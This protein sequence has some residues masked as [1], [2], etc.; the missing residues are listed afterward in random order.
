MRVEE[1]QE[2]FNIDIAWDDV[3]SAI[4]TECPEY[5]IE[6]AAALVDA[7]NLCR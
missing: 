5:Q 1:K 2:S 6:A 7:S 3:R 4:V